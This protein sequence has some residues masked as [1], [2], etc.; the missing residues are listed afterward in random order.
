[1]VVHEDHDDG[2]VS[3][4]LQNAPPDPLEDAANGQ[5]RGSCD[6]HRGDS[7]AHAGAATC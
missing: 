6:H 2:T 7:G 4:D 5:L 1:M 3:F